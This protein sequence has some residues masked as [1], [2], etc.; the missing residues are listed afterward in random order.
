L[1]EIE[2]LF[3]AW[4]FLEAFSRAPSCDL[5]FEATALAWFQIKGVLFGVGDDALAGD[6]SFESA[7]CA[8]YSLIVVNQY[9]CH[10][11]LHKLFTVCALLRSGA[12][13]PS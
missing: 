6:C 3:F 13:A 8:L 1:I 12:K 9:L 7:N 2:I 10:S 11:N 5:R 4:S